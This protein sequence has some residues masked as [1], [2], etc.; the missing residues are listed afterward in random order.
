MGKTGDDQ[1]GAKDK[2]NRRIRSRRRLL[3]PNGSGCSISRSYQHCP[4][5]DAISD[6]LEFIKISQD[7]NSSIST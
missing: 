7:E 6:C 5:S 3:I 1:I 2:H 4:V